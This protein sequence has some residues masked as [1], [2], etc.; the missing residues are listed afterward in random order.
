MIEIAESTGWEGEEMV[1]LLGTI[2][3]SPD[4]ALRRSAITLLERAGPGARPALEQITAALKDSDQEVRYL[5]SRSL[6]SIATNSP[7]VVT[8][9]RTCLQ[10]ENVM[11][12]NVATRTLTNVAPEVVQLEKSRAEKESTDQPMPLLPR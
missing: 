6:E 1:H 9:L 11:V 3:Q 5:A 2:L 12:R 4:P 10:D 8:A 7:Q